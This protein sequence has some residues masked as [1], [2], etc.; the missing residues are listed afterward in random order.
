MRIRTLWYMDSMNRQNHKIF[1]IALLFSLFVHIIVLILI[2]ENMLFGS[3]QPAKREPAEPLE[4]VF[5]NPQPEKKLPQKF[6]EI[7]EN[8]NATGKKPNHSDMLS[9]QSSV[10]Q[11]PDLNS[12]PLRAIPGKEVDENHKTA[13]D[14][15]K[16]VE[17]KRQK[18][19]EEAMFA[20][21]ESHSFDRSAL[22]GAQ[23][24]QPNEAIQQEQQRGE[25]SRRP[26]GFSA[27]LVGDFAFNT[28]AWNW[29]PYWLAFK[30]KLNRVWFAPPAY[31]K[32]GLIHGYTIV[33]V[34]VERDGRMSHYQVL[35]QVGH[36]SLQQSSVSALKSVFPF[37]ALPDDFPEDYLEV[38]IKMVYP[39]LRQYR[40][41][42]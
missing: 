40:A 13:T 33:R 3:T 19:L 6:Y 7:V 28:Y 9:T 5:E 30:R 29:A 11:A 14:P 20:Y 12:N 25:T 18:S 22:T 32:L 1:Y 31:W 2:N 37:R 23:E 42:R 27:D 36:E 10:S 21:R 16:G 38:T 35:Q 17:D 34:R 39:D 8:P 15:Q 41:D 24:K 4:L 26:E